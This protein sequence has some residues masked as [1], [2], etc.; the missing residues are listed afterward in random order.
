MQVSGIIN[1]G[2]I[3]FSVQRNK[4]QNVIQRSLQKHPLLQPRPQGAFP[5]PG[6]SS[7]GT[8]LPLLLA[9]RR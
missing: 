5:W 8:R 2:V 1:Y 9:S 7:L 3:G 6:K 4:S